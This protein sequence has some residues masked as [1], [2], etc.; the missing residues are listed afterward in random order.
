MV[1]WIVAMLPAYR[2]KSQAVEAAEAE[3]GAFLVQTIHGIRTVKSLALDA[4]QRHIWDVL[5]ARVAKLR[6]SRRHVRQF[7][8]GV[9]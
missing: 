6:F 7:D 1:L 4:R 8:S 9:S 5:T 3:R 2:R